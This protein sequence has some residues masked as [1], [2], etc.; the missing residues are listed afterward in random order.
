MNLR[1]LVQGRSDPPLDPL[2]EA[3]ARRLAALLAG[4]GVT[5]VIS[6]GLQRA[7]QTGA[8]VAQALALPLAC[9]PRLNER[10]WGPWEGR[11]REA[12]PALT[13]P[14][15][16]EPWA[17]FGDRI[18]A[19][20]AEACRDG[21]A[22]GALVVAHAGVFRA[23]LERLG[24]GAAEPLAHGLPVL[25][26]RRPDGSVSVLAAAPTPRNGGEPRPP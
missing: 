1:G 14:P 13:D 7:R 17:A 6:S 12:R 2:G 8:I 23:L 11:P 3:D 15:G 10:G 19:A 16:A 4:A 26:A 9:D 22:E 25:L 5:R 18:A 21:R 20:L 24:A